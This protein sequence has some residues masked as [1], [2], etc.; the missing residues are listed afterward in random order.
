MLILK[1]EQGI[2]DKIA[3]YK[4]KKATEPLY[5]LEKGVFMEGIIDEAIKNEHRYEIS[6]NMRI[7]D[8]AEDGTSYKIWSSA[9]LNLND[10]A[11]WSPRSLQKEILDNVG[12]M[13]PVSN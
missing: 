10:S 1:S 11:V 9:E 13:P 3:F 5:V 4:N 6:R 7:L 8:L 2:Y 12:P